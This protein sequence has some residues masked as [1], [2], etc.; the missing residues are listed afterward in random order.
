M[1]RKTGI[2][3]DERYLRHDAG[4]GHPE[5]PQR[6]GATYAMLEAPDMAGQFVEIEPRYA[7][8]EEIGMIHSLS[9]INLVASYGGDRHLFPLIPILRPHR[10]HMMLQS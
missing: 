10:N 7:T 4:F 2:V 8:H 9:Y 3:K 1:S 6:L 5:S